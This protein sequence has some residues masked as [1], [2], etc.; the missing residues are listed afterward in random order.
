MNRENE[1]G[2]ERK[3]K[4][5][6]WKKG[7]EGGSGM[8]KGNESFFKIFD[9]TFS[10]CL[11]SYAKQDLTKVSS[12]ISINKIYQFRKIFIALFLNKSSGVSKI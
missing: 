7:L 4:G 1:R 9:F 10:P 11:S 2:K 6:G 8:G 5:R 12:A 3:G